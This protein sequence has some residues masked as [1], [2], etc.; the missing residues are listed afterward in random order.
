MVY[1]WLAHFC[2]GLRRFAQGVRRDYVC[3]C[4]GSDCA[5]LRSVCS[6]MLKPQGLYKVCA[7]LRM[8]AHGLL[9]VCARFAQGSLMVCAGLRRFAQK[10]CLRRF[11]QGLGKV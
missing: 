7:C 9:M 2:A 11:A 1:A 6:G 10:L 5:G 8:F 3:A 4:V